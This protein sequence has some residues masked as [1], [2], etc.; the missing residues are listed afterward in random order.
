MDRDGESRAKENSTASRISY[1]EIL[2]TGKRTEYANQCRKEIPKQERCRP[3]VE[4][5][6]GDSRGQ[7]GNEGWW[8]P[9]VT[10]DLGCT[11]SPLGGIPFVKWMCSAVI[12]LM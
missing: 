1:G 11:S 8:Y 9:N 10:Q 2:L 12:S 6:T 4:G 7:R 3:S 5:R